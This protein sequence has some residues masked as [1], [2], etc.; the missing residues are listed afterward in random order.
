MDETRSPVYDVMIL[1]SGY[2][3]LAAALFAQ[4]A[5]LKVALCG[6]AGAIDFSTGCIDLM[7][8]VDG[9]RFDDPYEAITQV[10]KSN[11]EHP[12]GRM[13]QEEIE[14]ALTEF[15]GFLGS[16]GLPY[17][18]SFGRNQRMV[19]FAGSIRRTYS[20]PMMS[21]S[22]VAALAAT[23][24][25]L[26]VDFAGLKGF[27]ANQIVET[28]K[29][30]WPGLRSLRVRF[31]KP[32][33]EFYPEAIARNLDFP[34]KREALADMVREHV[35]DVEYIGFP[36][37]LGYTDPPA[38]IAHLEELL[39]RP[40]FEIPVMPPAISGARIRGIFER[41]MPTMG[42]ELYPQKT[43]E[44]VR[45]D[46][47]GEIEFSIGKKYPKTVRSRTTLL[48]TGRFFSKGIRAD[49]HTVRESVFDLPVV[50]PAVRADWFK[51]D[52]FDPGGHGLHYAGIATDNLFR[53]CDEN[54]Q[55]MLQNLYAAGSI[56]AGNDWSRNKSGAGFAIATAWKAVECLR[57]ERSR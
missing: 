57:A 53:P 13:A 40:V 10:V 2:A 52:F 25:T 49:R 41:H 31:P 18:H 29:A 30:D 16:I 50:Q 47:N 34:N 1:G 48:A 42:I 33:G 6:G 28:R 19:T 44:S 56:L 7:A 32:E 11:P 39:G 36:A 45:V 26:F 17:V 20:V 5:G 4:K 3:G 43:V 21:A 35:H 15:T 14:T 8:V 55:P 46:E 24:P 38:A 37:V 54:G 12:F 27:S 51:P 23:A 9:K 22:C